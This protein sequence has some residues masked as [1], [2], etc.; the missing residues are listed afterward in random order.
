MAMVLFRS[1]ILM[2]W[3]QRQGRKEAVS[4]YMARL[5]THHV[6]LK[7]LMVVVPPIL[8]LMLWQKPQVGLTPV[9]ISDSIEWLSLM[10]GQRAG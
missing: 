4:G 10:T 9:I 8:I 1:T 3:D 5:P 6:R 7:P 2:S